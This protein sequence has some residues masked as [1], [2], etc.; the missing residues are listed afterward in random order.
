MLFSALSMGK[1]PPKIVPPL[2]ISSSPEEDRATVIGNMQKIGK[3]RACG[4]GDMLADKHASMCLL[5]YCATA[6]A[7]AVIIRPHR[8]DG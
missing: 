5:Q 6:F 1:K 2:G 3:D 7:G 8:S 4:S